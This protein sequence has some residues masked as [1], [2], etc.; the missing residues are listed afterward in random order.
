MKQ[1]DGPAQGHVSTIVCIQEPLER[2]GATVLEDDGTGYGV[3]LRP[4]LRPK[5]EAATK[6]KWR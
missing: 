2:A 4:A 1:Q 5:T 3:R 6:T